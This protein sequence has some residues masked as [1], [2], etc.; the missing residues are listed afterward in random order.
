LHAEH[1]E[2]CPDI[3]E[4]AGMLGLGLS[5]EAEHL[6]VHTD[7]TVE[8]ILAWI[9]ECSICHKNLETLEAW[10]EEV[11][12][13]DFAIVAHERN[14]AH[15]LW[16]KLEAIPTEE[17]ADHVGEEHCFWAM[18]QLIAE[19]GRQ[20]AHRSAQRAVHLSELALDL[21]LLLD[22]TYYS[23]RLTA[24]QRARIWAFLG[25]AQR[26]T[27]DFGLAEASFGQALR[28]LKDGTGAALSRGIVLLFLGAFFHSTFRAEEAFKVL[29]EAVQVLEGCG[30]TEYF[31]RANIL[32]ANVEH[33]QGDLEAGIARL[34]R[35]QSLLDPAA[36]P[37]LLAGA[38][39]QLLH[40]LTEAGLYEEAELRI[41]MVKRLFLGTGE[42]SNQLRLRWV[43][44]RVKRGLGRLSEAMEAFVEVI[45][46][47]SRLGR[48]A[49]VGLAKL[50][51]ACLFCTAGDFNEVGRLSGEAL[52]A[53]QES[54]ASPRALAAMGVVDELVQVKQVTSTT[55][56]RLIRYLSTPGLQQRTA[57]VPGE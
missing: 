37:A 54:G 46:G 11:G 45:E 10:Q 38:Q 1:P 51:L 44:A 7:Q 43:E 55:I 6:L 36:Y 57:F 9:D 20:E 8:Q 26:I 35:V 16:A 29:E 18:A 49:E 4:L 53:F 56:L 47:L 25:N 50:D 14:R 15:E 48:R 41:E 30:S 17:L 52:A 40:L 22:E 23:P 3:T 21:S 5:P 33:L 27:G 31:A 39:H 34:T 13:P 42:E 2:V 24:D 32:L 28:N 19:K 12:Y